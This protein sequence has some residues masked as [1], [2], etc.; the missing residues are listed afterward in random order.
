MNKCQISVITFIFVALGLITTLACTPL[1]SQADSSR[2]IAI[3]PGSESGSES[4]A[5]TA[6]GTGAELSEE[7]IMLPNATHTSDTAVERALQQRRSIRTYQDQA[8]TLAEVGQLL[9]AAQGIT[10]PAGLRTAPSAGALYPLEFY[11]V[12]GEVDDLAAGVY[13]YDPPAHELVPVAAGDKRAALMEVALG[14]EA[15][16]DAPAVIVIAGIYER[17]TGKYGERGIRYV[18]MEVGAAAQN[19]YLQAE[20]LGLGTVFIGAF[21]DEQVKEVLGLDDAEEPLA[22]L[23]VGRP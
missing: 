15:V 6:V 3:A 2:P 12:A 23:P 11:L 8:L 10:D 14:Q 1:P 5:E 20:S 16:Q 21:Q 17:T 19:V 13:R 9:W 22:L 7:S 18:H 4:A